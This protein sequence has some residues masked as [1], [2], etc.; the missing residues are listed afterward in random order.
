MLQF[1][2]TYLLQKIRKKTH[3][4][5]PRHDSE[6]RLLSNTRRENLKIYVII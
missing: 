1:S 4:A 5:I 2:N 6:D 3:S